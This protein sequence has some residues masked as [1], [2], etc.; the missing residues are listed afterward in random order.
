MNRIFM[1]EWN[2]MRLNDIEQ[3]LQYMN[4]NEQ[5]L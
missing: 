4:E 5:Y 3:Y 2:Q 1:Y